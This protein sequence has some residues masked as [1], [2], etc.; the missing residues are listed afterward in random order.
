MVYLSVSQNFLV[1]VYKQMHQKKLLKYT[2]YVNSRDASL[3]FRCENR[4][5]QGLCPLKAL[6]GCCRIHFN[7]YVWCVLR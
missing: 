5:Q 3:L 4:G 6:F 2:V 7:P 1:L